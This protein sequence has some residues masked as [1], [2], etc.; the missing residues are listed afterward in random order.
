[1]ASSNNGADASVSEATRSILKSREEARLRH[2]KQNVDF[3]KLV[4]SGRAINPKEA[5]LRCFDGAHG[6]EPL[7]GGGP[8]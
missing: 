6:N 8:V 3:K 1:M 7:K 2:Q 5:M 4:D